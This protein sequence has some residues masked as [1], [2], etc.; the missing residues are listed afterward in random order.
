MAEG[1]TDMIDYWENLSRVSV[2]KLNKD[3]TLALL[4]I[5]AVEQHGRHLPIGTDS[6]I[7]EELMK[8]LVSS[9]TVEDGNVVVLPQ[10]RIGKSN[11]HM[12]FAGTLTLTARTL[13]NVLDE[14]IGCL[15]QHGVKKVMFTNSHG[16]NTDLLN[17]LSRD[18][19]IKYQIETYVFDWWFTDFW[20]EIM[21][22]EKESTSK[23]GVFHACELETS[24]MMYLRPE[25]V[26]TADI[27]DETPD[28]MLA[29]ENY[30]SL[31]GPINFG[32][33][34]DDV[35]KSGVIGEPTKASREKGK[36]FMDY[37]VNK[38][39]KIIKEILSFSY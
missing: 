39:R 33:K 25:L 31:Y 26:N 15:V 19:R 16:G 7:L 13:Y 34:T 28:K 23:Y 4:P 29:D 37:A 20:N 2:E 14:I 11:E 36:I 6:I 18:M 21:K 22:T 17:L 30:I 5:G 3:K 1:D 10:I 8:A 38:L 27:Y 35:S 9:G 12:D 24:L 32:W